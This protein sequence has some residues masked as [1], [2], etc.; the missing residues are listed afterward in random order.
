MVADNCIGTTAKND[1]TV[2]T[3][4]FDNI[5]C[6]KTMSAFY[7]LKGSFALSYSGMTGNENTYT[8]NF[9]KNAMNCFLRR[10]CA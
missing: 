7:K 6:Y 3:T 2:Y 8:I 10:K 4:D 5:I 9:N 1:I